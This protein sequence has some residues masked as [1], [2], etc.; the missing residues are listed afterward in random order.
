LIS[1]LAITSSCSV[2]NRRPPPVVGDREYVMP[3]PLVMLDQLVRR[4]V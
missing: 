3:G 2:E 4:E 1:E